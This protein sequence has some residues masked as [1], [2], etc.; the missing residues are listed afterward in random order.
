MKRIALIVDQENWAFDIEAKLL[1]NSLK[2]YYEIDVFASNK[3]EFNDDLFKILEVVKDYDLIHFFWRKLL[4]QFESDEFKNNVINKGY[5]YDNYLKNICTKISTGIYDH[6]F[7]EKEEIDAYKPIF[8]KYCK[9]YYTC[10]KRLE[11]IYNKISE[12]P[13]PWGT[14]HDTYDNKLYTGGNRERYLNKI[15]EMPLIVGWVGNSN[16]NIKYQDF[17][18]FHSILEP[19]I[20]SLIES[21]Y[22]ISKNYADRNIMFRSNEEMPAYYENIDVCI[23]VSTLEGT[24]RPII[25]GMA[26][27]VPMISTDVGIVP[28]VFGPLQKEYILGSRNNGKNDEIIKQKL[29]EKLIYLYE[30]REE[31]NNLSKENYEYAKYNDI[32]HLNKYYKKYFDDFFV[33]KN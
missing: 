5:N 22:N 7:L 28:E 24:P 25:E 14:I 12:Y 21:G 13:K 10:S 27:G 20:N 17:K 11:E 9:S 19:V 31:L 30:N 23:V 33:S 32:E 8:A 18:G 29:K 1:K 15:K 4:I 6:L 26:C 16:W 3:E 2:D